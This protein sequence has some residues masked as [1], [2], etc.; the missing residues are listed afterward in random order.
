[1]SLIN[2]RKQS[3]FSKSNITITH[4]RLVE[5]LFPESHRTNVKTTTD[6]GQGRINRATS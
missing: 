2:Y 1:M 6:E 4:E 3:R 5:L